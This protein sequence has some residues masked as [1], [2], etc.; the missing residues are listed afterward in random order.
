[1]SYI[2]ALGTA[3]P[4]HRHAQT[5]IAGFMIDAMALGPAEARRLRTLFRATGIAYRASVLPD[6]GGGDD[7]TFFPPPKSAG[8]L[9]GTRRRMDLFARHAPVLSEQ[10]VQ[11][12]W[13]QRP[14]VQ[15]NQITHLVVVSCTGLYAPGLDIDL[16]Q[17]LGLSTQV[18]RTCINFMGCYAA[19]N[20]LKLAHSFCHQDASARVLV[21]CTE[22]CSLHFQQKPT[23][24]NLL[25]N[26]L[27][28]DGAAALLVESQPRPGMNLQ[29]LS[30]YCDLAPESRQDMAWGVGEWGFEMRL[31]AYVPKVIRSG[32]QR[33]TQQLLAQTAHREAQADYFAIH[34]GGKK[35]L[36]AVEAALGLHRDQNAAAYHVL[37]ECGNMSSPTVLFVLKQL[38]ASM[39]ARQH[40]KNI[41]SFAFGPGL[42]LESMLL[43][44]VYVA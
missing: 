19:F 41:L 1:M 21:V 31:S 42:T 7:R 17:V 30:F 11:Q 40:G 27:F 28:A 38:V 37:R 18:Q 16:V 20:A 6:Y 14:E 29:P 2:T 24:D 3:T 13:R 34:P 32:M 22:L 15:P 8:P 43:K 5:D 23:P 39:D 25:A 33:L 9:P 35:I 36:E 26:A 12:V 10:A 44:L 4:R